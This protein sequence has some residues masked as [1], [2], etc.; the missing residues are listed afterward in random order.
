MKT[1]IG[2]LCVLC[3]MQ[4]QASARLGES[5]E[6]CEKR[7]GQRVVS[8]SSISQYCVWLGIMV[9]PLDKKSVKDDGEVRD[10]LGDSYRLFKMDKY[11][12][13]AAFENGKVECLRVI[14]YDIVKETSEKMD[15]DEIAALLN[16]NRGAGDGNAWVEDERGGKWSNLG[17]G[18][19]AS[20][21][22]MILEVETTESLGRKQRRIEEA[23][24]ISRRKRAE[25][26]QKF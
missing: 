5:L 7:Y 10:F 13:A 16:A 11:V 2:L 17:S 12:I 21:S 22:G 20:Y 24:E 15:P 26:L 6:E 14:K 4:L 23:K 19:H 25:S 3:L 8:K 18:R 1:I 9:S